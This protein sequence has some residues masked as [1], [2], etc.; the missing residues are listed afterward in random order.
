[1]NKWVD[2]FKYAKEKHKKGEIKQALKLYL[3]L[4]ITEKDNFELY[5]LIG[6]SYLQINNYQEAISYLGKSVKVKS[7]YYNSYNNRA[8]AFIKIGENFKA[9][10]DCDNAL[11]LNPNFNNALINKGIALKN[12]NK[13]DE[14]IKC[15]KKSISINPN[16]CETYNNL[17]NIYK[18]TGDLKKALEF[19]N[20]SISINSKDI[21]AYKNKGIILKEMEEFEASLKS[22]EEALKINPDIDYLHAGVIHS[23]MFLC[24]WGKFNEQIQ[25]L[26]KKILYKNVLAGPFILLSLFDDL[27]IQKKNTE[28][29][30]S[31]TF[32]ETIFSDITFFQKGKRKIRLAYF[33]GE[34]HMH[35]CILLMKDIY[36][37][38]NKSLFEIFAFSYGPNKKENPWRDEVKPYFN[39]FFDVKEMEDREVIK[40]AK[41]L[42]IDIAINLTGLANYERTNIFANR[43]API[44]INYLGFAGTMGA[45]FMDYIIAD[46]LII[47][48][49]LKKY[50]TEKI[51][52]LPNCYQPN[53][54]RL[55]NNKSNKKFKRIDFD[56]PD[57]SVVFCCFNNH[58]K[59]TPYIFNSWMRILERVKNSVIWIY[60]TNPTAQNNLKREAKKRGVDPN[61]IK[62]AKNMSIED[63]LERM[64]LA[65]IF[66]DT[67]PYNAHTTASDAIRV[68]LPIV[69]LIGKSFASRVAS[70]ILSTI[71]LKNL[72]AKTI[73]EYEEIAVKIAS[74]K[75][76]LD[77]LKYKL[78]NIENESALFNSTTFTKNLENIYLNLMKS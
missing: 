47:P 50:Y 55:L 17:G 7:N 48:D 59:I 15:L 14:A 74:D 51:I 44:Q 77:E 12:L 53:A 34:F 35:P 78:K 46:K 8:I 11:K 61:R 66:L 32:S 63:H 41:E 3:D 71:D 22:Y 64:K 27:G 36:K 28:N 24:D 6:T 21:D 67:W 33:S 9:I 60:T 45:K 31:K 52:Y 1:M 39:K 30:I 10:Q 5:Y 42:K 49:K 65:D 16:L 23:K 58:Y 56:L 57:K 19:Y 18:Q 62:F 54:R 13:F 20:K 69:T 38:H 68:G 2:D 37:N 29:H 26:K 75:K 25:S 43:V 72:I 40:I 73:N 70:S 4:E 76:L